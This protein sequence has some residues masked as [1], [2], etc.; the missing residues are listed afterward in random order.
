MPTWR[1]LP[2]MFHCP[3]C[4][5][6]PP[7]CDLI[8]QQFVPA[9]LVATVRLD[10]RRGVGTTIL[11]SKSETASRLPSSATRSGVPGVYATVSARLAQAQSQRQLGC[12]VEYGKRT[13]QNRACG[14]H[15]VDDVDGAEGVPESGG[16]SS[17]RRDM[18]DDSDQRLPASSANSTRAC[19][20]GPAGLCP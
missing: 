13:G 15:G 11:G 20:R 17:S 3:T 9:Q 10:H 2:G 7:R 6:R 5:L 12:P 8:Q 16:G 18:L 1:A 14:C 19:G 4:G